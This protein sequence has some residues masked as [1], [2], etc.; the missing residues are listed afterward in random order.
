MEN[1]SYLSVKDLNIEYTSAGRVIHAVNGV[2]FSLRRGETLG[3]VGETG[4]GKTSIA[5][6]ILRILPDPPAKI[7][8]GEILLNGQN[9]LSLSE[10]E[11]V[12]IRGSRISMIFQDPMTALNPVMSI[13]DQITEVIQAHGEAEGSAARKKALEILDMV[14]ITP[15]RFDEFPYQF[16]GGQKQRV[17]IALALACNP[18][19]LLAD[20]PTTALDV[21][22]Q[23]QILD[24][25]KDLQNRLGTSMILITHDLGVV[26]ETCDTV[27]VIYAGEV[28]EYGTKEEV[29]VHPAH[30]YT[31][32]LF[33]S[34]P[35]M[36]KRVR[37]LKP[38]QGAMPDPSDL[39][40]GCKFHPRCPKAAPQCAEREAPTVQISG[41]HIC[42]CWFA[43]PSSE[44][45][46]PCQL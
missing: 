44:E 18:E 19:L 27:A 4:A 43:V 14:G 11:M 32:G 42:K 28:I 22:I 34:L 21:T 36:S 3:L 20:E 5:K 41:S 23:A 31:N 25:M 12:D 15:E 33:S 45:G 29:F 8:G 1:N 2:S 6:A 10:K 35:N 40:K 17:V 9:L 46:I 13:G 24:M 37:R 39:P 26:A 38:I 16:S 7:R 30:P